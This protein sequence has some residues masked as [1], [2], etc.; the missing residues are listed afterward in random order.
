MCFVVREM[1]F[2]QPAGI[3]LPYKGMENIC[4]GLSVVNFDYPES[5]TPDHGMVITA[6]SIR[7]QAGHHIIGTSW[8]TRQ[9]EVL[10]TATVL[11]LVFAC[12]K[13]PAITIC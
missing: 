7:R 5:T 10:N 12:F 1:L 9:V 13:H 11:V 4:V 2:D 3:I 8:I 6:L